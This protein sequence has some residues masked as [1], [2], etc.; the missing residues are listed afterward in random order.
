VLLERT[1]SDAA[2]RLLPV[3]VTFDPHPLSVIRP[4]MAPLLLTSVAHRL[5]L[6]EEVGLA[7]VLVLPFTA[8]LA[9]QSPEQFA[10]EVLADTLH[11]R[12]VVVGRNFRFGHRAAGDVAQLVDLGAGLG[13]DTTVLELAPLPDDL[14]HPSGDSSSVVVSSTEIRAL[15]ARGDVAAAAAALHRAH[16]VSGRV[17]RGDQRGRELGYPTANLEV[18]PSI[19]IPADGVYA[20]RI[21]TDRE[22]G[23]WRPAAVSVGTNPTFDGQ[24]RRVEAYVIDAPADYDLYGAWADVEF[25]D[26]LRGMRRFATVQELMAVMADD[27]TRS[28]E[29]LADVVRD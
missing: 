3:A 21:R 5:E 1:V 26:R 8:Q 17:V 23:T 29:L 14:D 6:F 15:V 11:A 22:P 18:E 4:A 28:R 16:R 24:D 20:A 27:V 2:S 12:H 19:A 10:T 7:G 13:F 25:V 9:Q